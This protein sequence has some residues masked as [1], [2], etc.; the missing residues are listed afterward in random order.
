MH[1]SGSSRHG[2]P[3]SRIE[4]AEARPDPDA[5]GPLAEVPRAPAVRP[6]R[7]LAVTAEVINAYGGAGGRDEGPDETRRYLADSAVTIGPRDRLQLA[8]IIRTDLVADLEPDAA[9]AVL[10]PHDAKLVLERTD[11][12]V[13]LIQ[14]S[15]LEPGQP[16]G[17][18]GEPS[19]GDV[20]QRMLG[21]IEIARSLG[22]RVVLWYDGPR[23]A[24]PA[25]MPFE[26]HVDLVVSEEIAA[27]SGTDL[28]WSTGVQSAHG[29]I[30]SRMARSA[31][32]GQCR[33]AAGA[34]GVHDGQRPSRWLPWPGLSRTAWRSGS[35][36]TTSTGPAGS[37]M[38]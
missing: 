37:P 12:D 10:L 9:V 34:L 6:D 17:Y 24:V 19:A 1:G 14:S 11:P 4:L 31:R 22:R 35:T 20:A 18:G 25:L 15:A 36:R 13:V 3:S 5:G 2:S 21:V 16:W 26:S 7:D 38:L 29:S 23:H 30:P 8:G 32:R 27:G 28:S 33:I